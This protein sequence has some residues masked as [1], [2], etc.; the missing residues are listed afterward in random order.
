MVPYRKPCRVKEPLSHLFNTHIT[1]KYQP[2]VTH[3]NTHQS[4]FFPRF[5]TSPFIPSHFPFSS[6]TH[7]TRD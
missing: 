2:T 1:P 3:P 4:L 5:P 7:N 6:S